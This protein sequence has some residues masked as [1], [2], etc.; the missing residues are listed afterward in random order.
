MSV[1]V[2]TGGRRLR[3]RAK[4]EA[5]DV[6]SRVP[7][8]EACTNRRWATMGGAEGVGGR[9]DYCSDCVGHDADDRGQPTSTSAAAPLHAAGG[10][11]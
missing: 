3:R 1:A 4:R 6:A 5:W 10:E 2:V 7:A 9:V 8:R 11:R